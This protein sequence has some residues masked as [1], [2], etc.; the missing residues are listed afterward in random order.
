MQP[1]GRLQALRNIGPKTA[2]WLS[3]AGIGSRAELARV[4][5]I[6]ACR[7][8]RLAGRPVSLLAAYAIEG[9]LMD[10]HWNKLPLPFKQQLALDCKRMVRET[11]APP[12]DGRGQASS[13]RSRK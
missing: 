8:L 9:A 13:N 5:P 6:E 1:T 4:G 2:E 12:A 7:R 10:T 3:E 11:K